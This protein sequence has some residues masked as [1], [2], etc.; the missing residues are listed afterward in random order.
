MKKTIRIIRK[1][2]KWPGIIFLLPAIIIALTSIL[3][4]IDGLIN[5]ERIIISTPSFSMQNRNP[6]VK[7]MIQTSD[8]TYVGTRNGLYKV[9]GEQV[10]AIPELA[11]YDIRS[12]LIVNDTLF[13]ASRQGVWRLSNDELKKIS[14]KDASNISLNP[15]RMLLVSQGKKGYELM[16]FNGILSKTPAQINFNQSAFFKNH[17]QSLKKFIIDIH[18][19]EAIV[20]SKLMPWW[21]AAGAAALLILSFTGLW[22]VVRRWLKKRKTHYHTRLKNS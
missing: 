3:L 14:E 4:A 10:F 5:M 18:T 1:F 16:D 9:D 15:D 2:H 20:G 19:G 17:S 21:I 7:T 22:I 8:F 13:I 12:V 6:D 11:G